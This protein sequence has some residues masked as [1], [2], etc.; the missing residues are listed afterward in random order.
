[1]KI[2]IKP[3]MKFPCQ[4]C[5]AEVTVPLTFPGGIKALFVISDIDSELL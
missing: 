5:G 4:G 1:M 2:G 3:E